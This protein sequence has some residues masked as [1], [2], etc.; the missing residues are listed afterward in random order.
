MKKSDSRNNKIDKY[1]IEINIV[2]SVWL[3][4]VRV[5]K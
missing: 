1:D 4:C 5:G 2:F 3:A